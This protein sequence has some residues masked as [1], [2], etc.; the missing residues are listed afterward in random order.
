MITTIWNFISG[1]E[2][3]VKAGA[4]AALVASL[5]AALLNGLQANSALLAPL[6]PT[7]QF[8][9]ITAAP[10]LAVFLTAWAAKHTPRDD[11]AGGI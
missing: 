11:Q 10:T 9:I 8:V 2:A 6:S 7:L 3:K 5:L 4:T 1:V